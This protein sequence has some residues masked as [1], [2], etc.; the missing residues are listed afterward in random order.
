MR[1]LL[2]Q[3]ETKL[4][5]SG[6]R[7]TEVRAVF[8][9]GYELTN[10]PLFWREPSNGLAIVL[11]ASGIESRR[12]PIA[13]G[14]S[15][16][17]GLR[18]SVKPI[19]PVVTDNQSFHVL[20]VSQKHVRLFRGDRW[21]FEPVALSTLPT[22]LIEALDLQPTQRLAQV[23]AAPAQGSG[24]QG[25]MFHSQSG[26]VD[27]R[28]DKLAE[29]FR[30][31]DKALYPYLHERR[32]VLVFA[33]AE[34]LFPIFRPACAYPHLFPYPVRGNADH[35]NDAEL[36]RHVCEVL[37][38]QWK[39]AEFVDRQL[40]ENR[41]GTPRVS[42]SI[43]EILQ[44]AIDGRVEAMFVDRDHAIW[45][46]FDQPARSVQRMNDSVVGSE[47][48]L[49]RAAYEALRRRARVYAVSADAIPGSREIAAI[50]RYAVHPIDVPISVK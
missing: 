23:L 9:P 17:V 34:N 44:A 13:L 15:V 25:T 33:G 19:L 24:Q 8:Q 22:G 46:C 47:D 36:H 1:K 14:P 20:T 31:I 48:L 3:A 39:L 40:F 4:V 26:E 28:Q 30:M 37:E 6:M 11:S 35:L 27:R 43:D 32:S 42:T 29:W 12:L 18:V 38:G 50:Y 7:A 45:G 16:T 2:A 21:S 49:D 41:L 10:D 5:A